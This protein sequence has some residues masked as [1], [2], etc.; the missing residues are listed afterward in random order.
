MPCAS[1]RISTRWVFCKYSFLCLLFSLL[2]APDP[3]LLFHFAEKHGP[4]CDLCW[5]I[6]P[7]PHNSLIFTPGLSP[8]SF[9]SPRISITITFHF[10]RQLRSKG[11]RCRS[12]RRPEMGRVTS[13]SRTHHSSLFLL[14]QVPSKPPK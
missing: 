1:P 14:I 13:Q 6:S 4:L 11:E 9:L 10:S 2:Q 5:F 7:E 3:V 8:F 12:G